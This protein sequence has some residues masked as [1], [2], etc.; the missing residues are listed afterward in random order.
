[1]NQSQVILKKHEIFKH[2]T[3]KEFRST[4]E[5]VLKDMMS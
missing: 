3:A 4:L 1:M 5:K 2:P